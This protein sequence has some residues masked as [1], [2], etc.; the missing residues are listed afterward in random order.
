MEELIIVNLYST[1][2]RF[3]F[4]T[5]FMQTFYRKCKV[6]SIADEFIDLIIHLAIYDDYEL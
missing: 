6:I 1:K 2:D 4:Y 5:A 3:Y